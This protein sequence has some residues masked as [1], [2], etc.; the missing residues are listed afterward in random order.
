MTRCHFS[1]YCYLDKV[2]PPSSEN[3]CISFL[4]PEFYEKANDLMK[5]EMPLNISKKAL[6]WLETFYKPDVRIPY[7]VIGPQDLE[8][9]LG[10]EGAKLFFELFRRAAIDANSIV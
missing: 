6:M 10:Q 1:N 8:K 5:T 7:G 2:V 3:N 9:P 4:A